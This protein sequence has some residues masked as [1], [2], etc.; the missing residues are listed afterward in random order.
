L[1]AQG[2]AY[3]DGSSAPAAAPVL[4]EVVVVAP[5]MGCLIV[6]SGL[7]FQHGDPLY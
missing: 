3:S 1:R 6:V 4:L 5:T 2:V 7:G